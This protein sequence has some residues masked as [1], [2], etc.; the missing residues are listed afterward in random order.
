MTDQQL[1][2]VPQFGY[3]RALTSPPEPV[4]DATRPPDNPEIEREELERA[5]RR[6]VLAGGGH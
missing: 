2:Q 3:E 1:P 6:L 4:Q 5:Q